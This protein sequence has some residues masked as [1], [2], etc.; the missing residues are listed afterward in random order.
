MLRP[1]VV[2]F[3]SVQSRPLMT[4]AMVVLPWASATFT[5]TIRAIGATP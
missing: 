2:R 5:L 1:D 3:T 4:A